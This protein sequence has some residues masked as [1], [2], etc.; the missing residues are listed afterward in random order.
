MDRNSIAEHSLAI[1]FDIERRATQLRRTGWIGL[2][3]IGISLVTLACWTAW[4]RTRTWSPVELPVS[5]SQGSRF[6][7]NEFRSISTR[8]IG[9]KL[10][11]RTRFRSTLWA[12]CL[13][14]AC[15]QP[16]LC[17]CLA[18][19]NPQLRVSAL[20]SSF[21]SGLVP[22]RPASVDLHDHRTCRSGPV[23]GVCPIPKAGFASSSRSAPWPSVTVG[24]PPFCVRRVEVGNDKT[25]GRQT[26]GTSM[27]SKNQEET[28]VSLPLEA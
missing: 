22:G 26:P 20:N 2:V 8:S 11:R 3:M 7:T 5:L 10:M 17:R 16:A 9:L 19:T 13:A 15:D 21:E 14:T 12:A 25:W 27:I 28:E 4:F 24:G 23:G 6:R 18:I 1:A